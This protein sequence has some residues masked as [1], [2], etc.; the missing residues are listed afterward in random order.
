MGARR[1]QG[2]GCAPGTRAG[3]AERQLVGNRVIE[4]LAIIVARQD[5]SDPG[6]GKLARV[7]L[8][9]Q[10]RPGPQEEGELNPPIAT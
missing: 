6:I 4:K 7:H 9:L 2:K 8:R 10:G 1:S 3:V 5:D